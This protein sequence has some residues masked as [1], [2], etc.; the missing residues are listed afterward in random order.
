[1]SRPAVEAPRPTCRSVAR[2]CGVRACA[3]TPIVAG[4][5]GGRSFGSFE[6]GQFS[7]PPA[8]ER[9]SCAARRRAPLRPRCGCR[10]PSTPVHELPDDRGGRFRI[11]CTPEGRRSS[12]HATDYRPSPAPKQSLERPSL[13]SPDSCAVQGLLDGAARRGRASSRGAGRLRSTVGGVG[14]REDTHECGVHADADGGPRRSPRP[15]AAPIR[16]P[17]SAPAAPCA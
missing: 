16:S 1:M 5:S 9:A 6:D 14:G 12:A 17:P 3:P 2:E 4:V 11:P 10:L 7:T 15:V 13:P 8:P